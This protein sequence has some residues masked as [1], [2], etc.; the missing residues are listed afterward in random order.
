VVRASRCSEGK[1]YFAIRGAIFLLTE[2]FVLFAQKPGCANWPQKRSLVVKADAVPIETAVLVW[3]PLGFGG[4][5]AR[6]RLMNP[7]YNISR[8]VQ[9][10]RGRLFESR[11]KISTRG[12]RITTRAPQLRQ[13]PIIPTISSCAR[14]IGLACN[15]FPRQG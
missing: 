11:L 1:E 13:R 15:V 4:V 9:L 5:R 12:I 3:L 6:I 8:L 7:V 10:E 14:Y 2:R